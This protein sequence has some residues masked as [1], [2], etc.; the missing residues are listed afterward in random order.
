MLAIKVSSADRD[1]LELGAKIVRR[2]A[3][4]V[5]DRDVGVAVN[6]HCATKGKVPPTALDT[7]DNL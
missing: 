4:G 6:R 2:D 7:A 5:R 3:L 1:L